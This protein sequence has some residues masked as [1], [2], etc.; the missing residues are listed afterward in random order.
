MYLCLHSFKLMLG[1][2]ETITNKEVNVRLDNQKGTLCIT[3]L[4]VG[5]MVFLYDSQG[6]LRGKSKFELPSIS[7][8]VPKYGTYV[9]VMSHPNCQPEVRRII[10]SEK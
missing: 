2:M 4:L 5:T 1:E 7:M 9:L 8:L 10:Y 3:G 6:E